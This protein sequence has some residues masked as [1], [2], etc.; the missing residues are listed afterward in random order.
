M[1]KNAPGYVDFRATATHFVTFLNFFEKLYGFGGVEMA[2][3]P[4]HNH[5]KISGISAI[6]V[7][8]W[9]GC[10]GWGEVKVKSDDFSF[11]FHVFF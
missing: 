1:L 9:R 7:S 5:P 8:F 11:D 3:K 4:S 10:V 2:V 6:M